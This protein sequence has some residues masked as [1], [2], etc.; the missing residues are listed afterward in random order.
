MP[1]RFTAI[2][3]DFLPALRL[4]S[5]PSSP[6]NR[7]SLRLV[8]R[9]C[10][11][12]FDSGHRYRSEEAPSNAI[13]IVD[14]LIK[15]RRRRSSFFYRREVLLSWI[16][17]GSRSRVCNGD[18]RTAINFYTI[19]FVNCELFAEASNEWIVKT[20]ELKGSIMNYVRFTWIKMFQQARYL[21]NRLYAANDCQ[22]ITV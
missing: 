3:R 6:E 4:P 9:L 12:I 11:P 10:Y 15:H 7:V 18:N 19:I 22:W 17:R 16:V 21:S 1:S 20:I 14:F 13:S 5:W 2:E 8:D